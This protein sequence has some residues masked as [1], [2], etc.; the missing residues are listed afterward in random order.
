MNFGLE[1]L[2]KLAKAER[3]SIRKYAP[4]HK[5]FNGYG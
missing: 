2:G 1:A 3:K 4:I 5:R